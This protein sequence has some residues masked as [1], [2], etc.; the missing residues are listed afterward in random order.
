[1]KKALH[2]TCLALF[3]A[4][5]TPL[6]THAET[7]QAFSLDTVTVAGT[8]T[9]NSI[10]FN[11]ASVSIK[12]QQSIKQITPTNIAELMRDVP[13]VELVDASVSG[14]TRVRIRGES[15]RRVAVL[16]DGQEVTDHTDYGTPL[17]L[18]PANIERI[19]IIRGPSSVLYGAKAIGGVINI[20]TKKGA[21]KA[22]EL[23]LGGSWH[24]ATNG[25]QGTV[26]LSGTL[27]KFDYRFTVGGSHHD[28]LAVPNGRYAPPSNQLGNTAYSEK[29]WSAHLGYQL[30]ENRHHQLAIKASQHDISAGTCDDLTICGNFPNNVQRFK[31]DFPERKLN[32]TGIYYDADQLGDTLIKLHADIYYQTVDRLFSNSLEMSAPPMPPTPAKLLT[33]SDDTNINYGGTFQ[34]D[35]AFHDDHYTLIGLQYL[36]DDLEATK[37]SKITLSNGLTPLSAPKTDHAYLATLSSFIQNEWAATE[38]L[39]ITAGLRHY[40]VKRSLEKSS[41]TTTPSSKH[42]D[43]LLKSLGLVWTPTDN[44]SYRA[45]Y[46]EGYI[47]PSLSQLYTTTT[48]GSIT[49][50][51]NH[52]LKDETSHN[53]EIGWRLGKEAMLIDA[54]TYLTHATHYIA[55]VSC[56]LAGACDASAATNDRI[57]F[58]ADK[59]KTFG[60]ELL[61]EYEI[62]KLNLTPYMS[63]AW[64]KRKETHTNFATYATDTP[65]VSGRTGLRYKSNAPHQ[66]WWDIH[67]L[68]ATNSASFEKDPSASGLIKQELPGWATL[69]AGWGAYVGKHQKQQLSL[70]ANNLLNKSYRSGFHVLPGAERNLVLS[71]KVTL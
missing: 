10:R 70:Y 50:F 59:A 44:Q 45:Q 8:R 52:T 4:C 9:E 68:A 43:R 33:I 21:G 31:M 24:S 67:L 1:M 49:T 5:F 32:R 63:G 64:M 16:I 71:W 11:P 39:H 19:D 40:D 20:I 22:V 25:R 57:Y 27:D 56:A 18:D 54:S 15:S 17:L 46:S 48:A 62:D 58:N 29:D 36:M 38:Q 26:A 23:E 2:L 65:S 28:N 12:D 37:T 34:A 7:N 30:G 55:E 6:F 3:L 66:T 60:L 35:F 14:M 69:N 53:Y 47:T 42:Q 41:S 13:G 51:G 61:M